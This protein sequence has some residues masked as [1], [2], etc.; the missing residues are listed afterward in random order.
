MAN[1]YAN[2]IKA[3]ISSTGIA[4]A[5]VAPLGVRRIDAAD[6]RE[7]LT[8]GFEDFWE[9]PSHLLF[10]GI[11][12]PLAGLFLGRL[13]FGYDVLPLLFPLIAG[14]A[15]VGPFAAIG[16]YEISRRREEGLDTSWQHALDVL[17]SPS[18]GAIADL[19]ILS[20]VIYFAW[21]GAAMGLYQ[22]TFGDSMPATITGFFHEV[23]TTP[24]GWALII[25][26][27]GIGFI[28]A[29]VVLTISVV[30]FPLLIDRNVS[31]ATA[32][33]TSIR[34]VRANPVTMA[35]WGLV[36]AGGLVIGTLTLF[37][38]LA[39]VMPILGHATWHLYRRVVEH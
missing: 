28:F 13:A 7:A 18:R 25:L 9:K 34:A 2:A 35:L 20:M 30:S 6:I 24:H 21:L 29:V 36:V 17:R 33:G 39:I 3:T 23:L 10:L 11:I 4:D 15:L 16:L 38:G 8:K 27:N 12:Y 32:I 5:N 19:G 22:L 31:A 37:V 26:G 1:R 14:F